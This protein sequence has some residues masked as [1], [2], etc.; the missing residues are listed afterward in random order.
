MK[1]IFIIS[2]VLFSITLLSWLLFVFFVKDPKEIEEKPSPISE[3]QEKEEPKETS[4]PFQIFSDFPILSPLLS[5]DGSSIFGYHKETSTLYSLNVE[6]GEKKVLQDTQL[7]NPLIALW[8]KDPR[9]S[10]L[11]TSPQKNAEYFLVDSNSQTTTPLPS[12]ITYLNWDNLSEKIIFIQRKKPEE[13]LFST[14]KPDGSEPKELLTITEKGRISLIPVPQSPAIAYWPQS[15]NTKISP[16][17]HINLSSGT[18]T[19]IFSG[20]YGGDYLYSPDGEKILLS[21]SPEKNSSKL[22]LALLNKY[23]GQYKDLGLPTLVSKC[24]WGKNTVHIYCAVPTGIPQTAVM[25]DDYLNGK[26]S[27]VD[28]LWKINVETGKKER[29]VELSDIKETFDVTNIFIDASEQFLY[30][31]NKS[32]NI[33]YKV[34]LP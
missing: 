31:T 30:F 4:S 10:I 11:K 27:T 23:G 16:L 22:T 1:N 28:S 6:S 24:A 25:P 26:V 3:I 21:W 13:I 19:E 20:R 33:L 8:A 34:K 14:A 5:E 18:K 32:T 17:F 15:A 9:I 29:V 2:S 7:T 12:N